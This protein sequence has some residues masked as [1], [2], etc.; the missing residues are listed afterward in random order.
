MFPG[1]K[2]KKRKRNTG[3]GPITYSLIDRFL[4]LN[5]F[6]CEGKRNRKQEGSLPKIEPYIRKAQGLW[7]C[8]ETLLQTHSPKRGTQT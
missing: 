8:Q 7:K 1:E 2:G 5:Y 4:T 6:G 3:S